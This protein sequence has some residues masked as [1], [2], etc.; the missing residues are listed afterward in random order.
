MPVLGIAA[1]AFM[2]Y[3]AFVAYGIQCVYYLIVFAVIMIIGAFFMK[4]KSIAVVETQ[5]LVLEDD[6]VRIEET[7]TD[8]VS[9]TEK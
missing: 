8:S 6:N 7:I 5:K 1:C 9:V 2:V 3:C 4:E